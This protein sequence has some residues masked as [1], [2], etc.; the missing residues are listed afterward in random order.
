[1]CENE[2]V[3][4]YNINN[5]IYCKYQTFALGS[6]EAKKAHK[7]IKKLQDNGCNIINIEDLSEEEIN[8]LMDKI[9][10]VVDYYA[11]M[12]YLDV[13]M[14][15]KSSDLYSVFNV[16]G[17][18]NIHNLD[19]ATPE[20]IELLKNPEKVN[21]FK[22]IREVPY[23]SA[24]IKEGV[25][26]GY[27]IPMFAYGDFFSLDEVRNICNV[28]PIDTQ[29]NGIDF[30]CCINPT[31]L[32]NWLVVNA[33]KKAKQ[34]DSSEEDKMKFEKEKQSMFD[35]YKSTYELIQSIKNK[36]KQIVEIVNRNRKKL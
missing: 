13:N 2:L 23:S 8:L 29:R 21:E 31:S 24:N 7:E 6:E 4:I 35:S 15:I 26:T 14:I 27:M 17:S 25:Q 1:M 18:C 11:T 20:I 28:T 32:N 34:S 9:D 19:S 30:Q 22:N 36:K 12:N 10:A 5:N 33:Y 3:E 16:D